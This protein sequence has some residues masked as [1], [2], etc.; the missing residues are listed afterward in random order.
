L[1][2]LKNSVSSAITLTQIALLAISNK[3]ITAPNASQVFIL[4]ETFAINAKKIA[5]LVWQKEPVSDVR[6]DFT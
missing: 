2:Y 1:L 5:W 4:T 6:Q 3:K